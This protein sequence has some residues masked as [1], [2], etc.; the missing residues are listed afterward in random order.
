[1][2]VCICVCVCVLCVTEIY[3]RM[4]QK[5]ADMAHVY[6]CKVQKKQKCGDV[7]IEGGHLR[8]KCGDIEGHVYTHTEI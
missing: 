2:C 3:A 1:M 4:P 8:D 6:A 5:H 7:C